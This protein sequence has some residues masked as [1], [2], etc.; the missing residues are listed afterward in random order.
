MRIFLSKHAQ[1]RMRER[2]I[3]SKQVRAVIVQPDAIATDQTQT[4]RRIAKKLCRQ[5]AKECLL[6]V[7]YEMRNKDIHVITVIS[8][9]KIEKY[10]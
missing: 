5:H 8:T 10:L 7:I 4:Q 6:L 9:S 2:N 1:K 3:S